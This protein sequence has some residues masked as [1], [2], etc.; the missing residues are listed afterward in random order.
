MRSTTLLAGILI[1]ICVADKLDKVM[2]LA[3]VL[4]GM[5]NVLLIPALCHLKLMAKSK[6]SKSI[7]IGIICLAVFMLF[8]GPITIIQQW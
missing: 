6:L 8:F 7:D 3:G 1:S 2:A 4:L 5:S